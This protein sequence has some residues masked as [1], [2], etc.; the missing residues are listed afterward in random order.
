MRNPREPRAPWDI[1]VRIIGVLVAIV[2][3]ISVL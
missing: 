1:E 3:L 2:F